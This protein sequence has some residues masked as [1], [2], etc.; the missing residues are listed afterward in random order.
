MWSL[1]P[2]A[3]EDVA[4]EPR[5]NSALE[6][7]INEK[8]RDLKLFID[9]TEVYDE[10]TQGQ[11]NS[12]VSTRSVRHYRLEDRIEHIY[13]ILEKL[14]DHQTDVERRSG[15]DIKIRPRRQLE[16]WDF[17]DLAADGD[18]FFPRVAHLQTVGKGWVD[19]TRALHAVTLFGRGFGEL[20]QPQFGKGKVKPCPLWSTVPSNKYY[21]TAFILDLQDIMERDGDPNSNPRRL[22]E[23]VIWYMKQATFDLCPCNQGQKHH[24]P[25][26][27]L[28]PRHFMKNIKKKPQI[29][30]ESQGAVIFGHNINLHWHWRD[31]GDP[32]K[33]D[34][35]D[36][37]N[38][39]DTSNSSGPESSPTSSIDNNS[40]SV[41]AAGSSGPM[42]TPESPPS[43]PCGATP[44]T[45]KRRF[46]DV[47][48][49]NLK[50][51]RIS[52]PKR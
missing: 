29:D 23:K 35:Q 14:I 52:L 27:V 10:E 51:A 50:R 15:L 31:H 28:F 2:N 37:V 20:I 25:V 11:H 45:Q 4:G 26:Q 7:L 47:L 38:T 12:I 33:G 30:L 1:D 40:T 41:T 9:R 6:V 13:N 18:P 21:L 34:P 36:Q 24:D 46:Q 8:N 16:G 19:F 32:V 39:P 3:L 22:C 48:S 42:Q 49:S 43:D 44:N 17:K 5:S